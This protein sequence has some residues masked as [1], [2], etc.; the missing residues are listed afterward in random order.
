MVTAFC[1]GGAA[2]AAIMY[3]AWPLLTPERTRKLLQMNGFLMLFCGCFFST[4]ALGTAVVSFV[5]S[6]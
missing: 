3:I 1:L 4:L 6:V 2:A 5:Q